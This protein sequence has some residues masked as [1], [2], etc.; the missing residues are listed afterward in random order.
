METRSVSEIVA[1]R[2]VLNEER[3]PIGQLDQNWLEHDTDSSYLIL[4]LI[5]SL[6]S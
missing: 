5:S 3:D 1:S 6:D 2:R 4:S